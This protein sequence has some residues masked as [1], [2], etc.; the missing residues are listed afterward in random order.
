MDLPTGTVTFLVTDVEGS[1]RLLHELG[2]SAYAEA[3]LAHRAEIRE[4]CRANGGVE[5]DTQGDAFLV[6]F[7]SASGAVRA[8]ATL[9]D[10]LTA[11]PIRV[12]VG[13]HT[14]RPLVGDEG[15]VGESV[16]LAARVAAAAHGGQ[17][18]LT[19]AT[20]E[21]LDE[22]VP[23][24]A[25]GEHRLK[26][27]ADPVAIF[28]LG[29]TTFPPLRTISTTN[30]PRPASSFVG[31][32]RELRETVQLLRGPARVV[33]LTG[34]GGSGKTRLAIEAAGVLV[35]ARTAGVYWVDLAP[36][37]DPSDVIE[38]IART[39]GA[40]ETL[41]DHIRER[42]VLLVLDNFE[43]VIAA[44]RDLARLVSAC[45]NVTL[46]VTSR[47]LLRIQGE[48]EYPV[49]PLAA[50]DAVALFCARAGVEPS[51]A[52]AELC[53]RLDDLPLAVELAA[54]RTTILRP[55][56][57]LERL[58]RSL[59][60]L[61]GGRDLD[62]RQQTIRATIAWSYDLLTADEQ[63][64][65]ARL[66]VFVGGCRLEAAEAVAAADLDVLQSLVEKSLVRFSGERYRMLETIREFAAERLAASGELDDIRDRDVQWFAA[67][68]ERA[69][70]ELERADQ[71]VWLDRLA[72][73][74]DN[75]RAALG[76]AEGD[77]RLRLSGSMATF[78]WVHGDWTEGRRLL[79]GALAD[80]GVGDSRVRARALEGAAHLA[81]RQ[82]DNA[83]ASALAT[84]S[85]AI[86]RRLGNGSGIARSL[87]VLGLIASGEGDADTFRRRTE[88]SAAY[89][90]ASGDVWALSMAL[91]N[92]GYLALE[93]NELEPA[94]RWF[95]EAIA[96]AHD[97][98]DHRSEAFFLEN[99]A[100]TE[101]ERGETA[102][103]R[104]DFAASLRLSHRL[105]FVEVAATDLVGLAAVA[106]S[107]GDA[108]R[109]A[110]LLGG[111]E[112]LLE[113]TGGRWDP[114]EARVR[115]RA[116][117]SIEHAVGRVLLD[118]G[119]E[120]GRRRDPEDVLSD[121][122]GDTVA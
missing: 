16:H 31:R 89:A 1:T 92:L 59:D 54:A 28:Q 121:A 91:N 90:R 13:I 44:A 67:L 112:R 9:T 103:A 119:I 29:T 106:A 45:P 12:R 75:I 18:V 82:L 70:P 88:E 122:L 83:R 27:I 72:E 100:L 14:G 104:D 5:V 43:Q 38:T 56:Q 81:S 41:V 23:L 74:H 62:P 63:A 52:I 120:D 8:A 21:L 33:T 47:E 87:R 53:A 46:L 107:D 55:A 115:A 49:P 77:L 40:R 2:P 108:M 117:E 37:R 35:P 17:I 116:I 111:A 99:M 61:R 19:G 102:R 32:R 96:L 101:L 85:L 7:A 69:E 84:E 114:V 11:G 64:L 78:W 113:L 51:D 10:R 6:A 98:G 39:M 22:P 97:R 25:L 15:Y 80:P 30:L 93:A 118:E 20:Q 109:A 76:Y 60:F 42:D 94:G 3:L 79:D 110:R 65:F 71:D 86:C 50:G 73:E 48:V 34:P 68:V 26:D 4:A 36:L 24:V 95:G 57:I 105:G 58:G 66:S